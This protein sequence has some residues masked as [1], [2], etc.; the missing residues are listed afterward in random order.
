MVLGG[1]IVGWL[2][3][4]VSW[5]MWFTMDCSSMG[6]SPVGNVVWLLVWGGWLGVGKGG[7]LGV[8]LL[9]VGW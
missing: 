6:G 1:A 7:L 5:R 9:V 3:A 8:W 2:E 4:V